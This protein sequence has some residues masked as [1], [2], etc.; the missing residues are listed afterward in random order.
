MMPQAAAVQLAVQSAMADM[1]NGLGIAL[2]GMFTVFTGLVLLAFLLPV[3]ENWVERRLR[4]GEGK[5]ETAGASGASERKLRPDE[6]VAVSAAIHAHFCLLDQ[7]ENMKLTWEAYEK[8]Y[9]PWRL[10]GR[11]EILQEWG[12]LQNRIR[13]R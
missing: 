12:S 5:A 11:A 10:A 3:L 13:S 9:T 8:P 2:V 4:A 7:V 6:I 1:D